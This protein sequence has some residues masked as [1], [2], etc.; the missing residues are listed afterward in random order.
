MKK[1]KVYLESSG[2][3]IYTRIATAIGRSLLRFGCDVYIVNPKEFDAAGFLRFVES[4]DCDIYVSNA[5]S[6]AIASKVFDSRSY[7][8]EKLSS[9]LVFIHQDA[10]LNG[11]SIAERIEKLNAW[12]S[13]RDRSLHLCI[14]KLA[15][16]ALIA[17]GV[18]ARL[19]THGS[20]LSIAPP[21]K[22]KPIFTLNFVGHVVPGAYVPQSGSNEVSDL[23]TRCLNERLLNPAAPLQ[24]IFLEFFNQRFSFL[25]A[26]TDNATFELAVTDWLRGKVGLASIPYRG[27]VL[28]Q[29]GLDKVHIF[30]GDPAYLHGVNREL[31]ISGAIYHPPEH[32]PTR[33]QAIY[34]QSS[35]SINI[36]SPQFDYAVVN[37][38][39]DVFI[40]GGFCLTDRM[41]GLQDLT[42]LYREVSYSTLEELRS[43]AEFYASS[44]NKDIRRETIIEIQRKLVSK[45]AY[46][47]LAESLLC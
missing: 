15:V 16:D 6:N 35:V 24:P 27:C 13:V 9:K 31:Q 4:A 19:V 41:E 5:S 23:V 45:V 28:E 32:D 25:A 47:H 44:D 10:L 3:P 21:S 38:F 7:F 11:D 22:S 12:L 20:D 18:E 17:L 36:T 42:E 37:R 30:G 29:S 8:F 1:T 39:Y 43:K 14:E 34:N 46:S 33:V 2:T 26:S 40:S